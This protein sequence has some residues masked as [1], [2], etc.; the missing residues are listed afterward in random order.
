MNNVLKLI[1]G[2]LYF[3][4]FSFSMED[5]KEY[6]ETQGAE[7]I[8]SFDFL[9]NSIES[10]H[11]AK[12]ILRQFVNII[13]SANDIHL[14]FALGYQFAISELR[15]LNISQDAQK[16][17]N[18]VISA[19]IDTNDISDFSHFVSNQ[20][21]NTDIPGSMIIGGVEI[22]VGGLLHLVPGCSWI[23]KAAIAD[24]LRRGFNGLEELD[25][26]NKND[27]HFQNNGYLFP[28]RTS[29]LNKLIKVI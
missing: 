19:L 6:L 29:E 14:D 9:E 15:G 7:I 12:L 16:K 5:S 21:D 25:E 3:S 23:G 2:V 27:T 18:H 17:I 11:D 13:E 24:G 22:L 26:K 8:S 20:D 1:L 10:V 4:S 28:L